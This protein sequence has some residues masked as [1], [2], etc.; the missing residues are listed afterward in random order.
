MRLK[1]G[2]ER[3][4]GRAI[5]WRDTIYSMDPREMLAIDKSVRLA[6]YAPAENVVDRAS[7]AINQIINEQ[8]TTLRRIAW[9]LYD[10]GIQSIWL[11]PGKREAGYRI[12]FG[13]EETFQKAM[14]AKTTEEALNKLQDSV[15]VT[16][17]GGMLRA[18]RGDMDAEEAYGRY[19]TR[20]N[21]EQQLAS[22]M[23]AMNQ[24]EQHLE[25]QMIDNNNNNQ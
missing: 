15:V 20:R 17:N 2:A 19:A 16:P 11:R 8:R 23:M 13:K 25:S 3:R 18:A 5:E 14:F 1:P 12:M 10:A 6:N 21:R 24:F 4:E 22:Q 7:Y 9:L